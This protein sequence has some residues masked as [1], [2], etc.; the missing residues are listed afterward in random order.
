MG[1]SEP[2]GPP[3]EVAAACVRERRHVDEELLALVVLAAG[4]SR[5][6][7]ISLLPEVTQ[8]AAA[9]DD[10]DYRNFVREL[11]DAKQFGFIEFR[12]MQYGGAASRALR[13][14]G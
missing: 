4:S 5:Y 9:Y 10:R 12:V 2:C 7:A 1:R 8:G 14:A 3:A 13:L 6:S 11:E